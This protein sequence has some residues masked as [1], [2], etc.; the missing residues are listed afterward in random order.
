MTVV[1]P[2]IALKDELEMATPKDEDAIEALAAQ[3]SH[4]PFRERVRQ[5]CPDRGANDLGAF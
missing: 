1:V 2:D 3:R 4:E 5:R